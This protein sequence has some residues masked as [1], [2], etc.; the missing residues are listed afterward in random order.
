MDL[1]RERLGEATEDGVEGLMSMA[2][3]DASEIRP[4]L[5]CGYLSLLTCFT[6]GTNMLGFELHIAHKVG[7]ALGDASCP[8]KCVEKAMAMFMLW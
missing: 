6:L 7:F 1:M 4:Q 5:D 8:C 3:S 2:L